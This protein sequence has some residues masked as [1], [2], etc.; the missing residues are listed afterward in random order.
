MDCLWRI[1]T[2]YLWCINGSEDGEI[3]STE[4]SC[5]VETDEQHKGWVE[6]N[7]GRWLEENMNVDFSG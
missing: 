6:V 2:E 5:G 7:S 4:H 1:S 3:E